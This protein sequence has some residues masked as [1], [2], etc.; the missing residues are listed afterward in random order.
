MS[1]RVASKFVVRLKS[2]P[3]LW[4]HAALDKVF[5]RKLV[6]NVFDDEPK[7]WPGMLPSKAF[8]RDVGKHGLSRANV[9]AAVLGYCMTGYHFHIDP[10]QLGSL[11]FGTYWCAIAANTFNQKH[12]ITYDR[13]MERT[14]V[15]QLVKRGSLSGTD[16]AMS[17]AMANAYKSCLLGGTVL[18]V[19]CNPTVA[20]LGLFNVF[21][22]YKVY[23]QIKRRHW[24]NTQVGAIVGAIPPLMGYLTNTNGEFV[25]SWWLVSTATLFFWQFPHFYGL[26]ESR[27]AEYKYA[28]YKMLGS[29]NPKG[30]ITWSAVTLFIMFM[31]IC[32]THYYSIKDRMGDDRPVQYCSF[33]GWGFVFTSFMFYYQYS[34][35][36]G[37]TSAAYKV[38]GLSTAFISAA[39]FFQVIEQLMNEKEWL[40]EKYEDFRFLM[41]KLKPH[42]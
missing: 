41:Y 4:R 13:Q 16:L 38:F 19:G 26:A 21:L 32:A 17:N 11:I 37:V 36:K 5:C 2:S 22:Y 34:W 40:D 3:D 14:R 42:T 33:T 18:C 29:E 35:Y 20:A 30:A 24:L 15:R 39:V 10:V 1:Q 7:N 9:A 25:N 27:N 31:I 8:Y 12:E 6:K 23:T 28:G